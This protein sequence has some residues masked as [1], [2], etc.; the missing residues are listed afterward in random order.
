MKHIN[1]TFWKDCLMLIPSSITLCN[2]L[3]GLSAIIYMTNHHANESIVPLPA[4]WLILLAMFF[5]IF[6]GYAA[7]KLKAESIHGMQLDSFS[8]MLS[9]GI[10]PA[11]LIFLLAQGCCSGSLFGQWI[12]WSVSGFYMIC[13]MWRL[14]LYNTVALSEES[15]TDSFSGLPTPGAAVILCS[16]VL[17]STRLD[18]EAR[19][20]GFVTIA[21]GFI[22]GLMM[23]SGFKYNHFKRI[24][25]AGPIPFRIAVFII[26]LA[27][28]TM[29]DE[30]MFFTFFVVVHIYLFSGPLGDAVFKKDISI[31]N[32]APKL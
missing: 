25:T 19:T 9:F 27:T 12:A 8:D 5:D 7:R 3:C 10:A 14:A 11:I 17:L 16:M 24:V 6:D 32:P 30:F 15:S 21:Y 29:I 31:A 23:I 22:M 26:M 28:F 4:V 1:T 2:A 18:I 20:V 13:A